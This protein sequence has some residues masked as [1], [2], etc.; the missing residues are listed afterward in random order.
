MDENL[1]GYLLDALDPETHREVES[2]L[3]SHPEA[4]QRLERLRRALL[5]L[6]ADGRSEDLR[7]PTGLW[8]QTLARVAEYRCRD[9]PRAPLTR[10]AR[11]V[12]ATRPWWRRA[13]VLVAATLLLAISALLLPGLNYLRARRNIVECQNN[14]REV[15]LA[16]EDYSQRHRGELPKVEEVP[17]LNFA[18][19]FVPILNQRGGLRREVVSLNCPSKGRIPPLNVSLDQLQDLYFNQ[20][21]QFD[22]YA[23]AVGGCYAYPLGYREGGILHG[24]RRDRENMAYVPL[25]ADRPPFDQRPTPTL[26]GNSLNHDGQGQNVLY[27]DGSIQFRTSRNVGVGGDDI[28]LNWNQRVEAGLH[29]WDTVLGA[30]PVRPSL[31]D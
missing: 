13:D 14:L 11:A 20:R 19:V 10:A 9:L 30:S 3:Q 12:V 7:P 22:E 23:W 6:A 8:V 24:L 27:L 5:P 29:R 21:K 4:Q 18:G 28:Y 17:P 16:L 26:A 25:L 15:Y 31:T 2:Y 1:L